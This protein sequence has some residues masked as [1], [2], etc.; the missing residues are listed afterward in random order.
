MK[1]TTIKLRIDSELKNAFLKKC[2]D[3]NI[4]VSELLRTFI[5]DFVKDK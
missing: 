5:K 1:D 4:N 2:K 3:L